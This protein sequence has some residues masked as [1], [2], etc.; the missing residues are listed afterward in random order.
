MGVG[1][2]SICTLIPVAFLNGMLFN[3]IPTFS[4]VICGTVN[5][6]KLSSFLW[7]FNLCVEEKR[8]QLYSRVDFEGI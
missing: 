8:V 5:C 1:T 4:G 7:S 6:D 3:N 2:L